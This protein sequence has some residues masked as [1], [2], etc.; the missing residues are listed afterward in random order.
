MGETLPDLTPAQVDEL[1]DAL[2]TNADRL[3]TSAIAVLDLGHG[4]LARS[5]AILGIEESAKVIALHD[6][7]VAIAYAPEGAPFVDDR[8]RKLWSSHTRKLRLVHSFLV[9]ERYWF[10]FGPS[11]PNENSS[12][13]GAV[14]NWAARHNSL[15]QRGFYVDAASDGD[16]LSPQMLLDKQTLASVIA[17]VHQIGWQVRLGEHIEAKRQAEEAEAVP[18]A[19][20]A[21]IERMRE[22]LGQP[23]SLKPGGW[24]YESMRR[25]SPGRKLNNDVYRLPFPERG[26][27]VTPDAPRVG[28]EAQVREL[29][30]LRNEDMEVGVVH[31]DQRGRKLIEE[32]RGG[33][34]PQ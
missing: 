34:A 29:A 31:G 23:D 12:A 8:L 1:Q 2:L 22:L 26:R 30:R 25:G 18:P 32:L 21:D 20:D 4:A 7:R 3:L 5:L 27:G 19:T 14:E 17:F 15:K 6:R 28:F 9:D 13:L 24:H 33:T 10:G 11:D 16:V